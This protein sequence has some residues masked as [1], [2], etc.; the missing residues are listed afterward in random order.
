MQGNIAPYT[1]GVGLLGFA[2]TGYLTTLI[3]GQ[4]VEFNVKI[5]TYHGGRFE[6]RL[7][8]LGTTANAD[9]DGSKW[10]TLPLLRVNSFSPACDNPSLCGV[11]PCVAEKT[12][13][14]IPMLPY[15]DHNGEYKIM[16]NIPANAATDHAVVQWRYITANS[17]HLTMVS[18]DQSEMFWNCAGAFTNTTTTACGV[19]FIVT[20][21]QTSIIY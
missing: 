7:Q 17:C 5:T 20:C 8:D 11:E 4:D 16:V 3:A 12:C 18:C 2:N 14:Q 21:T 15:G 19:P 6:F 9:P 13:A 1:F 10:S